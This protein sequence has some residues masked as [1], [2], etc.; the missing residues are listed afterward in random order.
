MCC[1]FMLIAILIARWIISCMHLFAWQSCGAAWLI[2]FLCMKL[3]RFHHKRQFFFSIILVWVP[4]RFN[5]ISDIDITIVMSMSEI[6]WTSRSLLNLNSK[7]WH[8][9]SM[10]LNT[11]VSENAFKFRL[12]SISAKRTPFSVSCC[13]MSV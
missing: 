12:N 8:S 9:G 13:N 7:I 3:T 10:I 6:C 11:S 2:I 5:F 1:S 4:R